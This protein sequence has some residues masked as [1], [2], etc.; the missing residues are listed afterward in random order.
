MILADF[1]E[2]SIIFNDNEYILMGKCAIKHQKYVR[3]EITLDFELDGAFKQIYKPIYSHVMDKWGVSPDVQPHYHVYYV[4]NTTHLSRILCMP[5]YKKDGSNDEHYLHTVSGIVE[6]IKKLHGIEEE[7]DSIHPF[8]VRKKTREWSCIGEEER[9]KTVKDLE[10]YEVVF[11]RIDEDLRKTKLTFAEFMPLKED[12]NKTIRIPLFLTQLMQSAVELGPFIKEGEHTEVNM[13]IK[14]GD[15]AL[16]LYEYNPKYTG[17]KYSCLH[18]YYSNLYILPEGEKRESLGCYIMDYQVIK[19]GDILKAV[20]CVN[21]P[22]GADVYTH[23]MPDE[24]FKKKENLEKFNSFIAALESREY[25]RDSKLQGIWLKN[26]DVADS[27][28]ERKKDKIYTW[29]VKDQENKYYREK[30]NLETVKKKVQRAEEAFIKVKERLRKANKSIEESEESNNKN[31]KRKMKKEKNAAATAKTRAKANLE[32]LHKKLR[33]FM[34]KKPDQKTE[35]VVFRNI[36]SSKS[37][38]GAHNEILDVLI[39]Y[40]N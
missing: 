26:S 18:K 27:D 8:K 38:L 24:K 1:Y 3:C 37:N 9:S 39:S 16:N 34:S 28:L 20:W 23:C 25:N 40:Y 30:E 15:I 31:E 5:I 21:M 33:K 12:N 10:E 6:Y 35:L 14:F 11:Y 22:T 13:E 17:K 32:E 19:E 7:S 2:K 29:L 36:N 4:D